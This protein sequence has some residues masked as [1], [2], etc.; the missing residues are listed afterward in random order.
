MRPSFAEFVENNEH[1]LRHALVSHF[2]SDLG[3]DAAAEALLYGLEH[4]ERLSGMKNPCGY[5]YRVG[6]RWGGRQRTRRV[7][8]GIVDSTQDSWFEPGLAPALE[9]LPVKQRV[10]VVLRHGSDMEY[11]DIAHLTNSKEAT[12]RKNVERGLAG[13]RKAMEVGE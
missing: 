6:Q 11:S 10:A 4:W 3:R 2:G 9:S 1:E 5:L 7:R 8:F 12:V 13:L